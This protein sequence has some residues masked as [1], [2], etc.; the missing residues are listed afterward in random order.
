M[1]HICRFLMTASR[2]TLRTSY[3]CHVCGALRPDFLPIAN[4]ADT[5]LATTS[6]A[7]QES[8][9]VRERTESCYFTEIGAEHAAKL[10]KLSTQ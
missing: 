5:Q 9:S 1:T 8:A 7:R 4:R 3:V 6:S 10:S 2:L